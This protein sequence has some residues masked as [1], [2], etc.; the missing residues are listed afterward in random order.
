MYEHS[1]RLFTALRPLL[2]PSPDPLATKRSLLRYCEAAVRRLGDDESPGRVVQ[3]LFLE[4]RPL[5]APSDALQ[6][7]DV[8]E[9]AVHGLHHA[10]LAARVA[11]IM[12][13]AAVNRRQE[14]C[15][16][17]ALR[18][19]P[20]CAS[21]RHLAEAVAASSRGTLPRRPVAHG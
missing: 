7:L 10:A 20:Y 4:V 18:G 9:R 19:H 2:A 21:H 12:R 17:D 11:P 6:A 14:P 5:I 13:C 15:G 1:R 16:R 3:R 8:V